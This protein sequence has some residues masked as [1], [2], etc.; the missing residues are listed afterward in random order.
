[1][2]TTYIDGFCYI[3]GN[4]TKVTWPITLTTIP[5]VPTRARTHP[6]THTHTHTHTHVYIYIY[7]Y[8]YIYP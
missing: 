2:Y 8:I 3:L 5:E 1:M 7:I 6:S 4:V